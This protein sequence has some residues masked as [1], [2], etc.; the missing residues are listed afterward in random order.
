LDA[1]GRIV[2]RHTGQLSAEQIAGYLAALAAR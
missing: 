2:A 1:A